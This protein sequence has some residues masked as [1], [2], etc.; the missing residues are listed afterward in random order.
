MKP[1]AIDG[2][3]ALIVASCWIGVLGMLRMRDPIQALHYVSVPA[4]IGSVAF[5]IA[6]FVDQGMG[7]A[8]MKALLITA[9]LLAINSV[10]APASARAFRK[11]QL[12]H[13]EPRDGDPL[14]FM[15]STHHPG[16]HGEVNGSHP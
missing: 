3:L 14:E 1:L 6:V 12:G 16:P 4:T 5:T 8:S 10:V 13:W 2:L 15:P 11:R 7:V 9:V